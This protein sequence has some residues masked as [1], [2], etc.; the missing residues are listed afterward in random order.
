M[1]IK[2]SILM[3][4]E[5]IRANKLRASLTLLSIAIGVFS[6]IGVGT[7]IDSLNDTVSGTMDEMG[8]NVFYITKMPLIEGGSRNWRKLRTRKA[9]NFTQVKELKKRMKL[10]Q[11]ICTFA[12]QMGFKVKSGDLETDGN[13]KLA[14][15]D[16]NYFVN[17][18]QKISKGRVLTEFDVLNKKNVA[19]IGN[20][21]VVKVFPNTDPI[22]KTIRIKS[23]NFV[24][25]GIGETKGA[26][27]GQ[28]QDNYA[29]I[30]VT[31]F[32]QYYSSEWESLDIS[33]KAD[34]KQALNPT[35][36]EA[37]GIMRSIRGVEPWEENNFELAT[38][39]SISQQF[40]GFTAYLAYFG[41]IC[42]F[43]S[44]VA[45]GVGIMNIM[46]VA[47][48]ERTREIGIRKAVGAR[49][50]WI[51]M[52]FMIETIT[53][54]QIGGLIGIILGVG[55]AFALGALVGMTLSVPIFW[56]V[57]SLLICTALGIVSGVYPAYKAAKLDPIEALRYE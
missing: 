15:V 43:I 24:V 16:E 33:I 32:M 18:N 38:N 9:I 21:V 42:G 46:L 20:D 6:I 3:A 54:C 2:E 45:A 37:I 1:N 35:M 22:G 30:P 44:L 40:S 51:L 25:V 39:D 17:Y 27:M 55:L 41:F 47:V 53:L 10:S 19:I 5:S 4:F 12:Q 52:Q 50:N 26:L 28:S 36:D 31:N 13:V 29:I 34:S 57:I 48:K 49:Q 14:G 23:Q 7:L 56:I 11:S 8:E